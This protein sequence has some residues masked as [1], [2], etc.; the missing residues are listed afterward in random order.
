[1]PLFLMS[2]HQ[3]RSSFLA[4]QRRRDTLFDEARRVDVPASD[5]QLDTPLRLHKARRL[6]PR[7]KVGPAPFS[8]DVL[9]ETCSAT[10]EPDAAVTARPANAARRERRSGADVW[11]S[12]IEAFMMPRCGRR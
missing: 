12:G 5:R 3:H 11:S 9:S 4:A 7:G 8:P 2:R 1:M 10:A 6:D